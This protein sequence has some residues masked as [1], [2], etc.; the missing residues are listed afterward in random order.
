MAGAIISPKSGYALVMLHAPSH[1]TSDL[2]GRLL[3]RV[4]AY[5]S[6]SRLDRNERQE[7]AIES[8][9]ECGG[10]AAKWKA[11]PC[12]QRGCTECLPGVQGLIW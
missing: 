9:C 5:H 2:S 7:G 8:Q 1:R 11:N 10:V 6:R 12:A 4:P 3:G